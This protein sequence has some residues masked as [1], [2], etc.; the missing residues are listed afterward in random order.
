MKIE[1]RLPAPSRN[2]LFWMSAIARER[3]NVLYTQHHADRARNKKNPFGLAKALLLTSQN[4]R[5]PASLNTN[6]EKILVCRPR[7]EQP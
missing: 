2:E 4:L 5:L 6:P 7:S 3:W 1:R